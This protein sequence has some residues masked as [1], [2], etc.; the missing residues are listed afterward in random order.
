MTT[1]YVTHNGDGDIDVNAPM[2]AEK[3]IEI[4]PELKLGYAP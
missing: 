2:S 3:K 1:I 4:S